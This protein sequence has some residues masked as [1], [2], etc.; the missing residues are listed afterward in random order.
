[1]S[2]GLNVNHSLSNLGVS[3]AQPVAQQ[4]LAEIL[5]GLRGEGWGKEG[6]LDAEELEEEIQRALEDKSKIG[7]KGD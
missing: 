7:P 2:K 6:I 3:W 1:M 5:R 4:I